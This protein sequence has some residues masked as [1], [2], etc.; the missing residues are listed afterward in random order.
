MADPTIAFR[1]IMLHEDP[2]ITGDIVPDPTASD[3]AAYSRF[4]INSAAHP[5]AV[6]EGFYGMSHD[7]AYV[8]AQD[9]F[10]YSYFSPCGGY[11]ITNQDVCNKIV[12]LAFNCGV[13]QASKFV[14]R[15]LTYFFAGPLVID[16]KIGTQTIEAIN[17]A[18]QQQLLTGIKEQARD[19][20]VEI[21]ATD[22]EKKKDLA[23]WIARVDA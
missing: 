2:K 7:A 15:A 20:Y 10:K 14:Q 3:K 21:A 19:F 6:R 11:Q 1:F 4:G 13:H 5:E 8:Y 23:G 12:D 18:D 9:I 16:G 22:P 17:A